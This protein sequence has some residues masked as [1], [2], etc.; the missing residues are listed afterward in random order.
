M[1][2]KKT[3][4]ATMVGDL[5][6]RGHLEFIRKAKEQGDYLIIGL[7]PDDVAKKYKRPPIVSFEDRKTILE[8]V[9]EV[10]MVVEDCMDFRSPAMLE[11]LKKYKVDVAVHG[12]D[13]LPPLYKRARD[14]KI[15]DVVQVPSYPYISTTKLLK[16]IRKTKN[17]RS[18]LQEKKK[19]VIVSAGD[20]ITA[21]LI[22]EAEFDGI[23]ISGFEA[24]ARMGMADNGEITMTEMLNA[25]KTVVDATTLPVIVDADNGYGGIHNFI[26]TVKEFEKAGVAGLSVEDNIFPKQNSLW[27]GKVPLLSMEEHGMKIR[28]GKDAQK[29]T[30][31]VIIA[32]TEALIRGYGMEEALR[33]A[34]HYVQ[35]GADMIMIHSREESGREALD[36]PK[37]WKRDIPLVIV[38]TKFPQITN[39]QLFDSGF[40]LVILANQTERLKIKAIRKGLK[41]IK[42][43]DSV[44]PIENE[45]SATLDDLRDLTPINE[46][47]EIE[48]RYKI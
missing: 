32:R 17:L 16:E 3:V 5:F 39:R 9:K 28:A 40:S 46:V 44:L 30:D 21:K 48:K 31:F 45:L 22:E 10:D 35:C 1:K 27:G 33:R 42:D 2:K 7:H 8:A 29:T 13:W 43:N 47:K 11:N 26:R 38:P 25:A 12:D 23:W 20:A 19:L 41:L 4:Y 14:E 15:C 36:I 37:H 6:H 18:L 34:E 24:S